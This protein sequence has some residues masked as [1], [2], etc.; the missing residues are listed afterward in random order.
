MCAREIYSATKSKIISQ[1]KQFFLSLYL[2]FDDYEINNP[3]GSHKTIHK[4]NTMYNSIP[5]LPLEENSLIENIFVGG[6][7]HSQ[8]RCQLKNHINLKPSSIELNG[9]T[10]KKDSC[11]VIDYADGFLPNPV[12]GIVSLIFIN[13]EQKVILVCQLCRT[14]R[15]DKNI[16]AYVIEK[17]NEYDCILSDNL[18][19]PLFVIVAQLGNNHFYA[20]LRYSL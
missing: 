17:T 14:V 10:H 12:F 4:L 2:Y 19:S 5:C 7:F 15:F 20:T 3:L 6:L 11:V 8:D 9:Q 18:I 16:H 13:D 1:T